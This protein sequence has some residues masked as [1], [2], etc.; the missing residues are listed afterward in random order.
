MH[1]FSEGM[2]IAREYLLY[3]RRNCHKH[4]MVRFEF[5]LLRRALAFSLVFCV[6]FACVAFASVG[7]VEAV[8]TCNAT[9]SVK[10]ANVRA[11]TS[12][13]TALVST[14]NA[15]HRVQ[16]EGA[17]IA[18]ELVASY[19]SNMWYLVSFVD[20]EGND[21]RG[22]ILSPLLFLDEVYTEDPAF[23]ESIKDFPD[24]YKFYLRML[25]VKY[26][27]WRFEPQMVELDWDTVVQSEASIGRSL[28]W[29]GRNDAWKST[30]TV[31]DASLPGWQP[32]IADA[33]NWMTDQYVVY[34]AGGW[35]NASSGIIGYYMDPR[36]FL[37][38][39]QVF[40]FLKLSYDPAIHNR[41]GVVNMV[42]GTTM[43]SNQIVNNTGGTISY[44][45]SFMDAAAAYNVNPYFLVARVRQEV[46]LG[47]GSFSGSAS[48]SYPGYEGY[49]NFYN[50]GASSSTDPITLAL[51]FA[52]STSSDPA[53]N[54]GRPWN[55]PY[56]AI[57]GGASWIDAGYISVGQ[58]TLYLQKWHVIPIPIWGLY[59][60]QYMTNIEAAASEA[61]KLKSAYICP[62]S[63]PLAEQVLTFKIP[64]YQNMPE[65]QTLP[66]A[67]SGN[68]NNWLTSLSVE[69]YTLTPS[70][71]PNV[72]QYDILVS[73]A[74]TSINVSATKASTLSTV[75][76]L[77]V[78][79]LSVGV[80]AIDISVTAQNGIVK[81]YTINVVRM[82]ETQVP[83]FTTTY[84]VQG[85]Y[86]RGVH[87][88]QS[89]NDFLAT[90]IPNEGY[91]VE[92]FDVTGAP[93]A[94]DAVMCT[95]DIFKVKNAAGEQVNYYII[96][97]I[98]DASGD[99]RINSYDLTITAKYVIKELAFSG[100]SVAA[101][102][103]NNDGRVNSF[104]LT[105]MA[106]HIIKEVSL[107]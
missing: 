19:N 16:V 75:S 76:G 34:D 22:Y 6:V 95:G 13:A 2:K 52:Q 62:G 23:E 56:K 100:S 54:H 70:F 38:D 92:L 102:D 20:T 44:A 106:K 12:T 41:D 61:T 37:T 46:V 21:M 96:S 33:Y 50:I 83:Q 57:L 90:I 86:I 69:G 58:D 5:L 66:P 77:G 89:I 105:Q 32:N 49:Y 91:V 27:L 35:V 40:Q 15:G 55:T 97:V 94:L 11:S 78:C 28:I 53:K 10:E 31:N 3:F 59:S 26:P 30:H 9:V 104:D 107:Y 93:K 4:M 88:K 63:L 98:G 68:P 79:E 42:S 73:S 74:T 72:L 25:H 8:P 67:K 80:N 14:L 64:V 101:A 71:D 82:D 65:F 84:T 103:V 18:G 1:C 45:E 85:A 81:T 36:N 43:A 99:G 24:S 29:N 47:D 87:E 48:G 51:R 7:R 60:H 39:T 17:P